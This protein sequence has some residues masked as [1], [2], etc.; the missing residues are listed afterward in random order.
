MKVSHQGGFTLLELSIVLLIIAALTRA[1]IVPLSQTFLQEKRRSTVQQLEY[2]KQTLNGYLMSNGVLPCPIDVATH[3]LEVVAHSGKQC[4][5]YIGG[6]P[7]SLL[8][9]VGESDQ[10][11][12]LLNAWGQPFIYSL[13]KSNSSSHG[14]PSL[15]DWHNKGEPHAVGAAQL[16]G[17]LQICRHRVAG[18]CPNNHLLASNIVWVVVSPGQQLDASV[19]ETENADGDTVFSSMAYSQ[20]IDD[21]FDDQ[22]IWASGNELVYW[23]L[24]ANWLP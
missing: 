23:L 16:I 17:D 7:A 14:N 21:L 11:G 13:S 9:L 15:P 2:I 12:A 18:S 19:S 4:A 24:K 22:L 8:G 6:V 5:A 1:L 20:Q 3:T 10:T